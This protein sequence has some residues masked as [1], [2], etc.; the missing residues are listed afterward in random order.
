MKDAGKGAGVPC[1][2]RTASNLLAVFPL[3]LGVGIPTLKFLYD[4]DNS[5]SRKFHYFPEKL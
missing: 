5:F 2:Y 3:P 1:S 4:R